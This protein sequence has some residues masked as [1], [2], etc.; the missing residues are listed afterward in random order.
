MRTTDAIRILCGT[1]LVYGLMLPPGFAQDEDVGRLQEVVVTAQKRE[2]SLQDTPISIV[3]LSS[4]AL[5]SRGIDGLSDLHADVPGLVISP[6]PNSGATVRIYIRGIGSANDQITYDPSVA[7][8]VDGVYLAR[9]QGLAA[10]VAELERVEIL[11]GPQGILYGRNS[12][13]GAINFITKAPQL[14]EFSFRQDLSAGNRDRLYARTRANIP[15][16]ET[17]AAELSFLRVRQD[18]FI[19]NAGTGVSRFGDQDRYA[20]RA[21]LLWQPNDRFDLRYTFD[22]SDMED[23]PVYLAVVPLYPAEASAPSAS[24]PAVRDSSRTTSWVRVTICP[25]PSRSVIRSR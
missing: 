19:R 14:G 18:G 17:A 8:Y 21:A 2:E 11:R 5:E 10:E 23:T 20:Y 9:F 7:M 3:A 24:L 13:G 16:G 15:M 25:R 6:H 4:E 1:S 22:R 12:T